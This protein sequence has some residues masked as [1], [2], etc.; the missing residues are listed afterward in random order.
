MRLLLAEAGMGLHRRGPISE[1]GNCSVS[2][3]VPRKYSL[4]VCFALYNSPVPAARA[5]GP[6]PLS[7]RCRLHKEILD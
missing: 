5:E 4:S 7:S 2:K 6:F 1:F 3:P